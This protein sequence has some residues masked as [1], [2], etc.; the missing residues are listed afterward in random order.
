MKALTAILALSLASCA[1]TPSAQY[2]DEER[3]QMR[4]GTCELLFTCFLIWLD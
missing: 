1:H 2:V 4:M 3:S